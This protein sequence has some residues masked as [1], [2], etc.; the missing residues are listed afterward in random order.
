L[1]RLRE[2]TWAAHILEHVVIEL[3]NLAG[4]Q[5]GFGKARETH[6]RGV[7]KVAFR[8]RQGDVSKAALTA[9]CDLLMAAIN[10]QPFDLIPVVN[11]LRELADRLCLGPSTAHIVD[12]ATDRR[13][14][15]IRLTE[16]NLVQFGYGASQH[17]IWTA[18]TD[19]TSAIA[20]NIAS[21]KQMTKNLLHSCGVPVPQGEEVDSAQAAWDAAQDIGLPVVVKPTDA[22][23]G[24]GVFTNLNT[25]AEIESAY[26]A[27]REEGGGVLVEKFIAGE[28]HRILVVGNQVVGATRGKMLTVT[29]DGVQTIRELIDNQINSDPRCGVEEE[30]PLEPLILDHE[31][32]ARMELE[33]QGLSG[34]SV[35]QAGLCVLLKRNGDLAY[36]VTD[37]VHPEVARAATLAARVVGLDIAGIDLVTTDV[38]KSL[39]EQGG[40][41]I[42][43]NAGPGLLMHLKPAEGQPRPVGKAIVD[44]LFKPHQ[45]GRIPVVGIAGSHD[46]T[47]I[48]RL[49]GWLLHISGKHVGIACKDGFFLGARQVQAKDSANWESGQRV[50]INRSVEAA[51]FENSNRMILGEGLAYDRCSVGVVTD[52]SGLPELEDFYINDVDKLY[53][54]VRTQVDVILPQGFAVLNAAESKVVEMAALCDGKVIFYGLDANLEAIRNHR[55]KGERVVF[56]RD[57]QIVLSQGAEEIALLPLNSLKPAKAEKPEM[58]MAAVAAAWALNITPELIGAGMRTFES[59]PRKI[60]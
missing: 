30:F 16:G 35:P 29:G 2:G 8:S 31:P 24:R 39:E 10:N 57:Q 4:M 56:V 23:H 28:G 60:H 33:R 11:R 21:D 32:I 18:E 5:T 51:V 38:S 36:D 1:L 9:A 19:Q 17:R 48:A 41:L 55:Q 40:A 20:E 54:V 3:Q 22:N 25:R 49:V 58:V 42:E 52:L 45:D 13:I 37:L 14:P 46:S 15:H 26:L 50:L 43:V 27:A 53:N 7:Y 6:V 47:R 59:N 34:E 12:A 44:H